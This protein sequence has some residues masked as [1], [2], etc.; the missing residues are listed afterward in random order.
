MRSELLTLEDEIEQCKY[1]FG[2]SAVA[3]DLNTAKFNAKYGGAEPG[4]GT[5][6]ASKILF[7]DY[8][9]D[10]WNRAS[11]NKQLSADLPYCMTT[12][13]GCGHCG[14]GVPKN[15][16]ACDDEEDKYVEQWLQEAEEDLRLLEQ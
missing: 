15:L 3:P 7:L 16:T 12:C 1:V 5:L 2:D 11:V 9:D 14:A 10:P 8:S 6:K 13:D 4:T